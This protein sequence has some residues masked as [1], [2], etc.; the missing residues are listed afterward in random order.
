M[1]HVIEAMHVFLHS[2]TFNLMISGALLAFRSNI[3]ECICS[4][5][6][7]SHQFVITNLEN[8]YIYYDQI[9]CFSILYIFSEYFP[10]SNLAIF[11][12]ILND[13]KIR[14]ISWTKNKI[15]QSMGNVKRNFSSS[16]KL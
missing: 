4:F 9:I 14:E 11:F 10:L 3:L 13:G 7:L 8:E 12:S 16:F 2:S 15:I 1:G 5:T 6:L